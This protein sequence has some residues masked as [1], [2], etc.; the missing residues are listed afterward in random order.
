MGARNGAEYLDGLA[1]TR[2]E[3]W[4]GGDMVEDVVAHPHCH[5]GCPHNRPSGP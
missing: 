4:L 5:P 2:R 3:I 1:N